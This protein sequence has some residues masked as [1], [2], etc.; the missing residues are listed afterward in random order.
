[1]K[2][3]AAGHTKM[4]RLCRRLDLPLYQGMGILEALWHLTGREAIQGDIGKLSNED[5]ALGIDWRGSEDVLVEALVLTNWID[6][7]DTHRLLI[8]DWPEHADDAVQ[9]K[10]ARFRFFFADGTPPKLARLG[11]KEREA[12]RVWYE[13]NT[14]AHTGR[15]YGHVSSIRAH[16]TTENPIR[17][18]GVA[19]PVPHQY[20]TS[21]PPEP[22][23][24]PPSAAFSSELEERGSEG[25]PEPPISA[26]KPSSKVK[27]FP[28][29]REAIEARLVV[30]EFVK[31]SLIGYPGAGDL[32]GKPDDAI[33]KRCLEIGGWAR[34]PIEAALL[35][36]AHAFKRPS[37]SWAWFPTVLAQYFEARDGP[38]SGIAATPSEPERPEANA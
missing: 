26:A 32:P 22:E 8:H 20:P 29:A 14:D 34:P 9:M 4:K 5:I 21:T 12:A 13:T 11:G 1:M 38:A 16:N 27:P 17:A 7:D 28:E 2:R 3:E 23:P 25:K 37:L 10:L 19:L 6:R 24:D 36:M 35:K 33:V 15:K 31:S 18:H 30:Y